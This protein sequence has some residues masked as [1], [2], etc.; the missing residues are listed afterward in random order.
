MKNPTAEQEMYALRELAR[1]LR[2]CME[3]GESDVQHCD[4]GWFL[5]RAAMPA[6]ECKRD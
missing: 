2:R 1:H 3:C 4:E 5:W 6:E